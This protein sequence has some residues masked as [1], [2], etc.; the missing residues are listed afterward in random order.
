MAV[1]EAL[2]PFDPG[3]LP[4]LRVF[5]ADSF[6]ESNESP[7]RAVARMKRKVDETV[8]RFVAERQLVPTAPPTE[9][10]ILDTVAGDVLEVQT[11]FSEQS[12]LIALFRLSPDSD[13]GQDETY[14]LSDGSVLGGPHAAP[15][16]VRIPVASVSGRHARV[17]IAGHS[18][19]VVDLGSR[20]GTYVRGQRLT[21]EPVTLAKGD[22]IRL[23][24]ARIEF[25]GIRRAS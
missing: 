16:T 10:V 7:A 9:V 1:E 11:F 21:D 22:E 24:A 15:P 18:A 12:T 19:T 23:G 4:G 3:P 13:A 5:V 2:R 6:R 20:H 17:N 25:L 14:E 8:R